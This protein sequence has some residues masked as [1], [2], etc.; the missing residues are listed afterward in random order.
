MN[1]SKDKAV[2]INYKMSNSS[3]EVLDDTKDGDLVY[4]HGHQNILPGLEGA[5][6]GLKSGENFTIT[7]KPVDAFGEKSDDKIISV[8]VEN[9]DSDKLEA[10][11]QFQTLD[12][13][14]NVVIATILEVKEKEVVI[15]ENHPLAGMTIIFEGK[16][17]EV[18]EATEEEISHGH[19]HSGDDH[20]HHHDHDHDHD[21]DG[22]CGHHH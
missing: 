16:V 21:H 8:G 19:I 2:T 3:G 4:L 10:G 15:D 20:H 18:R 6:D 9:F 12:Q 11:M 7:L 5:L 13:D 1:V 14:E 22:C 17:V